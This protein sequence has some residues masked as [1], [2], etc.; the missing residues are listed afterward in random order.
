MKITTINPS[1]KILDTIFQDQM[2]V[3]ATCMITGERTAIIDPGPPVQAEQII[4]EIPGKK[5]DIIALTHI[6][7]DHA[8]GTWNILEEYPE[9]TVIVHPRGER[10]LIDPAD[11]IQAAT[12]Q[13]KGELPPYGEIKGVPSE[14]II[15][16]KDGMIIDLG[17]THL[18]VLWTPGH[19]THSQSFY[20][21]EN[22]ILFAGDAAGHMIKDHVIPASPPPYN[23]DQALESLQRMIDLEPRTICISHFGFSD[24]A[25]S[26]LNEFKETVELWRRLSFATLESGGG[27]RDYY[28]KVYSHDEGVQRMVQASPEAKNDVYGSLVG[29]FSY[30]QWKISKE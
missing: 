20:V 16:S 11:L 27:L 1:T 6:H 7:L 4:N 5:I 12:T 9:C 22:R 14:T 29:F 21:R 25:V 19:S 3:L 15:K 28:N 17:G 23:P 30:A 24:E 18:Q 8:A 26:Y 13:F 10:H 2:G